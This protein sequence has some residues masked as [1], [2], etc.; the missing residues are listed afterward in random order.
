MWASPV[1]WRGSSETQL[2]GSGAGRVAGRAV[3]WA[4]PR[5][6]VDGGELRACVSMI[7]LAM[8]PS[9]SSSDSSSFLLALHSTDDVGKCGAACFQ[10]PSEFS[11]WEGWRGTSE[12]SGARVSP[13]VG[14]LRRAIF[15]IQENFDKRDKKKHR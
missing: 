8:E 1:V 13:L 9:L 7:S 10:V 11:G 5:R 3:A 4:A 14:S 15:S 12:G 6:G 2:P